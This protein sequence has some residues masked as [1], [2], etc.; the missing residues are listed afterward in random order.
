MTLLIT[1]KKRAADFIINGIDIII[2]SYLILIIIIVMMGIRS[3]LFVAD[4]F[5]I[6]NLFRFVCKLEGI[7]CRNFLSFKLKSLLFSPQTSFISGVWIK[8]KLYL[9]SLTFNSQIGGSLVGVGLASDFSGIFQLA[10]VDHQL[11]LFAVLDYLHPVKCSVNE[12]RL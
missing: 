9:F 7:L 6:F 10:S 11:P 4:I 8:T 3:G 2:V 5:F 1:F 12:T